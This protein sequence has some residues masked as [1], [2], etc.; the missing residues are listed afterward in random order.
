LITL[1]APGFSE[2]PEQ[3]AWAIAFTRITFAYL[4]CLA[5]VSQYGA[6]LNAEGKFVAAASAPIMLNLA[7]TA[8]L[9]VAWLFPT[10]GHAA[11]YGVLVGGLLELVLL[12]AG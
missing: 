10:A 5:I 11:A 8:M 4:G 3:L 2:R 6:M 9:A 12:Y 7:M 1:L